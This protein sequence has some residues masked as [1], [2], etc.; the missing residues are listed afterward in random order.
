MNKL[1]LTKKYKQYYTAKSQPEL[2][3]LEEI[4]YL[5]LEGQGDPSGEEYAANISALYSVAYALKFLCKASGNDFVVARLEGQWW[6]DETRYA[7]V[8]MD[9]APV[10]IPRAQWH[11]RMLIRMPGLVAPSQVSEAVKQVMEKKKIALAGKVKRF[12][13]P[14]TQAVQMLHTGPFNK[15]PETLK[16]MLQFIQEHQLSRN[17]V[18]HEIYLSDFRKTA[19]DKLKTI[20]RE[21]VK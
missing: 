4:T 3:H 14:A 17:G 18:H 6:F 20:L 8:S 15:E 9:D 2:I 13:L 19:A 7:A 21:P 5:S 11:Y 1:D 12:T 16:V 10:K